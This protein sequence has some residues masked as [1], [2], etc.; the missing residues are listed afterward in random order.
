[1][2]E[3]KTR[4]HAR[5]RLVIDIPISGGAWPGD[6]TADLIR[7][8]ATE[9]AMDALRAGFVVNGLANVLNRGQGAVTIIG[10]PKVFM[11]ITE[12]EGA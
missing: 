5:V 7:K 3:T 1:M 2:S 4:A 9:N 11:I 6:A 8:Q 12:D 10:E